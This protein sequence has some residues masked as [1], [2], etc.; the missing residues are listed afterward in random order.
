MKSDLL[1]FIAQIKRKKKYIPGWED[2]NHTGVNILGVDVFSLIF[3]FKAAEL[4]R[5]VLF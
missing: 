5:M 2:V 4:F 3:F 1:F